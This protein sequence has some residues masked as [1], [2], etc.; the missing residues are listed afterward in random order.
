MTLIQSV[1]RGGPCLQVRARHVV[2]AMLTGNP[3]TGGSAIRLRARLDASLFS[4]QG[5]GV[6]QGRH[7]SRR[8]RC[9]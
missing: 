2:G 6:T 8:D 7:A 9:D 3:L 1:G 4:I 5:F